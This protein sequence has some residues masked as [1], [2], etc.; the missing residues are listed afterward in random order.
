MAQSLCSTLCSTLC[1][2]DSVDGRWIW[3]RRSGCVRARERILSNNGE[4]VVARAQPPI[5]LA[6]PRETRR[7][8]PRRPPAVASGCAGPPPGRGALPGPPAHHAHSCAPLRFPHNSLI[9]PSLSLPLPLRRSPSPSLSLS[10]PLLL[11]FPP[12][13]SPS[14][15]LPMLPTAGALHAEGRDPGRAP[16][17]AVPGMPAR[18][19]RTHQDVLL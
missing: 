8:Q 6:R 3:L 18:R 5:L 11:P 12:S 13:A 2:L 4:I 19:R 17:A 16:R 1:R 14:F 10:R 7:A 15:S 9:T